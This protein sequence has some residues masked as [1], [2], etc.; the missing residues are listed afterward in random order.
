MNSIYDRAHEIRDKIFLSNLHSYLQSTVWEKS[1]EIPDIMSVWRSHKGEVKHELQIPESI[2]VLDYDER[3][4]DALKLVAK[5]SDSTVNGLVDLILDFR[6]DKF[7]IRVVHDDTKYGQIPLDDG[8]EL[9]KN[10]QDIVSSA[11]LAAIEKKSYFQGGKAAEAVNI[12]KSSKL[13]QS[14]IGSYIVNINVPLPSYENDQ[15]ES[16]TPFPRQVSNTLS[17]SLKQ[18]R[19]YVDLGETRNTTFLNDSVSEGV[20]ANLCD[21]LAGLSGRE[22]KRDFSITIHFSSVLDQEDDQNQ[23]IEYNFA[24][25]EARLLHD[26]AEYLKGDYRIDDFRAIG[27]IKT[28]DRAAGKDAG[29]IIIMVEVESRIRGVKIDLNPEQYHSAIQAHENK[30][31]VWCEGD[32]LVRPR[33]ATLSN[34]KVFRVLGE[35]LDL[36]E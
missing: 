34:L 12:I 23:S 18:L 20:S 26:A 19:N 14:S 27:E 28:L 35:N 6:S 29:E 4:L 9:H 21:A 5:L 36:F 25:E 11:A 32:L 24:P 8:V 17:D 13:A 31:P 15:L 33:S 3:I 7:S 30:T 2:D 22:F 16:I 10:A 1:F